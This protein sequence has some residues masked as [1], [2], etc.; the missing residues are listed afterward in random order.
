MSATIGHRHN[1][2]EITLKAT[3]NLITHYSYGDVYSPHMHMFIFHICTIG[4]F[5]KGKC[6]VQVMFFVV[7]SKFLNNS[8]LGRNTMGSFPMYPEHECSFLVA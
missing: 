5:G 7:H 1:M 6:R 3:L 4:K 8:F 2:T